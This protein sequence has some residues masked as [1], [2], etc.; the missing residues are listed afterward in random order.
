MKTKF[1]RLLSVFMVTAT[2]TVGA[3]GI[4]A[5]AESNPVAEDTMKITLIEEV[6]T[7]YSISVPLSYDCYSEENLG[8]FTASASYVTLSFGASTDGAAA[9]HLRTGGFN[10]TI[11]DTILPPAQG[12][13]NTTVSTRV[14]VTKGTTYYI[15]VEPTD[16]YIH[17]SGSF[18]ITY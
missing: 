16:S 14:N 17:T 18:T 3:G 7:P 15:T 5:N 4:T 8:K 9:I 12:T 6:A 11:Y 2:L 10:G 1:T 13:T